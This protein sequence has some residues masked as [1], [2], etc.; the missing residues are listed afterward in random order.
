MG[1]AQWIDAM[2]DHVRSLVASDAPPAIVALRLERTVRDRLH[3]AGV[4]DDRL[5]LSVAALV[6]ALEK[7]R[8]RTLESGAAQVF[9]ASHVLLARAR[10]YE[11]ARN[12]IRFIFCALKA[13]ATAT[14]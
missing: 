13:E 14:A 7:E 8:R 9:G 12:S 3:D 4:P 6:T 5:K 10:A 11:A 2:M 1:D